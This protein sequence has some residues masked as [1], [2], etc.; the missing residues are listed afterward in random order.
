MVHLFAEGTR[1]WTAAALAHAH[2]QV[3]HRDKG[4]V[5]QVPPAK[6]GGL[7][8]RRRRWF[9][10]ALWVSTRRHSPRTSGC[11]DTRRHCLRLGQHPTTTGKEPVCLT[12]PATFIAL[13]GRAQDSPTCTPRTTRPGQLLTA[14]A[15][16]PR[17]LAQYRCLVVPRMPA[18]C[19]STPTHFVG[20][21][22]ADVPA[23][24]AFL[25]SL[26]GAEECGN[27]CEAMGRT[28]GR[29]HQTGAKKGRHCCRRVGGSQEPQNATRALVQRPCSSQ[30][31][32]RA[33]SNC[34]PRAYESPALPLSYSAIPARWV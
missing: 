1:E 33:D 13:T 19:Q 9:L 12:F 20:T 18:V 2:M 8:R 4:A 25:C 15:C 23:A 30:L 31:W 3:A 24:S 14:A 6:A 7:R 10:G 28:G 22:S 11:P 26:Q 27:L 16:P 34:R 32:R 17:C 5:S 29:T 21:L